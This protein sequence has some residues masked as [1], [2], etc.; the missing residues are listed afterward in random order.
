[1]VQD[2]TR[3]HNSR[4]HRNDNTCSKRDG[5]TAHRTRADNKE[6]DAGNDRR[7]VG[8]ENSRERT[9]IAILDCVARLAAGK[10]FFTDALENKH[11]GVNSHSKR[12]DKTCDAGHRKHGQLHRTTAAHRRIMGKDAEN[13]G[14]EHK[15][16]RKKDDIEEER[17]I[18]HKAHVPVI[19]EHEKRDHH[20]A[21]QRRDDAGMLR[22][23][24][25][26]RRNGRLR[27]DLER[28]GKR[29]GI[30]LGRKLVGG[31]CVEAAGNLAA[32][33]DLGI[34]DRSGNKRFIKNNGQLATT[35]RGILG[36]A[37]LVVA[38]E[39]RELAAAFGIK[40]ETNRKRTRR[41]IALDSGRNERLTSQLSLAG[42]KVRRIRAVTVILKHEAITGIGGLERCK[43][44]SI[45][46]CLGNGRPILRTGIAAALLDIAGRRDVLG[47]ELRDE[48][49]V[50]CVRQAEFKEGRALKARLRG[51][52][53]LLIDTRKL[54]E[55]T[56]ILHSL[57]DRLVR[58]HRIDSAADDLNNAAIA[59]L[60]SVLNLRLN[61]AR[62]IGNGRILSDDRFGQL[63]KVD[64]KCEG[65]AALQIKPETEFFRRRIT[66]V[67]GHHGDQRQREPLPDVITNRC[68][69]CH[70]LIP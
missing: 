21:E 25:N 1:M 26:R 42:N 19:E 14:Y 15:R 24:A 37:G 31:L 11:V 51:L 62:R 67:E 52:A 5:E 63:L 70:F 38:R 49:V 41:R 60:E 8:V 46:L 68:F 55:Q 18:G 48:L 27:K 30:Q 29:T 69:L 28:R 64:T 45:T 20:E 10:E 2:E 34:D 59:I 65:C 12:E 17:K 53:H 16:R 54:D 7:Q 23:F 6:D 56:M 66:D 61:S 22:I 36:T 9:T 57:N 58:A 32:R 3:N 13:V 33:T 50:L 47:E 4:E 35:P 44:R 40:F 43:T 39:R